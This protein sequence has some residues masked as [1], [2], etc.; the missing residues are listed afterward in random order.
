[1]EKLFD[2]EKMPTVYCSA[3]EHSCVHFAVADMIRDLEKISG[4]KPVLSSKKPDANAEKILL[5]ASIS[6]AA[7]WLSDL[8]IDLSPIAGKEE[9][10]VLAPLASGLAII[11]SDRRGTMWGIYEF[12]RIYLKVDPL[13]LW[14]DHEPHYQESLNL[15]NETVIDGPKSYRFRGWFINDEDLI[16]GFCKQGKPEKDYHYQQDYAVFLDMLIET[17]L[18]LKQ[19]MLIP[20]SH[21]DI[22]RPEDEWIIKR[23]TERGLYI[24]MH[25]QEPVGI[26]QQNMDRY[27]AAR[28]VEGNINFVDHTDLYR[29]VWKQYIHRWAQYEG[30]IWQLGLRGRGDR[31]VW[32]RNDRVPETTEARGKLISDAI[33]MQMDLIRTECPDQEIL[34]TATLWMEGMPLYK[35]GALTFPKDTMVIQSDFGPDQM[36]G[37][38]YNQTP[39]HEGTEYGLYYHLA[40]WGCGPHLIQGNRPEKIRFNFQQAQTKGD[41][42]Y[43]V[44]NVS[45]FREFVY[46][47]RYEAKITWDL[48]QDDVEA[49]RAD[50]CREQFELEET[51]ALEK[52]YRSYFRSFAV[53]DNTEFPSRMT[54]NDGMARR[55]AVKLMQ[56]ICGSELIQEDIQNKRLY[57]FTNTDD[58]VAY[59]REATEGGLR[60]FHEVHQQAAALLEQLPAHRRD[61]FRANVIVQI[62]I[63]QAMYGWVNALCRAAQNRRANGS[64]TAYTAI[65]EEAVAILD[66]AITQR[67]SAL[68]SPWEHWYDGDRLMN[69]PEN[70]RLTATLLPNQDGS[71]TSVSSLSQMI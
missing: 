7:D 41:T 53:M 66:K 64:D 34:S 47:I 39:R 9:H 62:E 60:R 49:D 10:F 50:W 28:G 67:K 63:M 30:V 57:A 2:Q 54:F 38:G 14:T 69:L 32:Y 51:S 42:S 17:A 46:G 25:H 8:E 40:F 71:D 52:I 16:E 24:S 29:Q 35:A 4:R 45:N 59:Y 55:V 13:Y 3:S 56:I 61:F 20:C 31:P 5:V 68:Y 27:W 26:N 19:N 21:L 48:A 37:E 70:R 33:Q 36:W 12:C 11:G 22:M 6:H 65:I 43:V 15:P 44:L 1:M 58:F 23:I 18:R